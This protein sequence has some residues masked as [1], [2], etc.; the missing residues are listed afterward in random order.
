MAGYTSVSAADESQHQP[1]SCVLSGGQGMSAI[2]RHI[3]EANVGIFSWVLLGK[4]TFTPKL[5]EVSLLI[6][7]ST[8]SFKFC[9]SNFGDF[10]QQHFRRRIG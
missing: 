10:G 2:L 8:H 5:V 3:G 1:G 4:S 6:F 7:S 9:V